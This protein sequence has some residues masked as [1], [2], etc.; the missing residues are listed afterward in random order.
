MSDLASSISAGNFSVEPDVIFLS[1]ARAEHTATL[2][3]ATYGILFLFGGVDKDKVHSTVQ[4]TADLFN[5]YQG[6]AKPLS[7]MGR[8]GHTATFLDSGLVLV[9][10]GDDGTIP[11]TKGLFYDPNAALPTSSFYQGPKS[12]MTLAREAHT[13]TKLNNGNI[14]FVGGLGGGTSTTAIS[15]SEFYFLE[16]TNLTPAAPATHHGPAGLLN[17]P[18]ADHTATLLRKG[19][20]LIAGGWTDG[21][22]MNA[23]ATT[24][25]WSPS[26]LA[27]S[28][29][30]FTS[31]PSMSTARAQHTATLLSNGKVLITGGVDAAGNPLNTAEVYDPEGK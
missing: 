20:V 15:E 7:F 24:E 25:I 5:S 9:A 4:T 26:S 28:P 17:L 10:G 30:F 21:S 2:L 12:V 14:L 3:D 16:P 18:R 11:S 27:T 1:V 6:T 31:G 13:A 22:R 8:K 29:G 23:T 19:G